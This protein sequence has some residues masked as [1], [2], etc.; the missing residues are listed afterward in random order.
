MNNCTERVD[1]AGRKVRT[2][3]PERFQIQWRDAS[4]DQLIPDD[5]R[6]RAVWAFVESLES[7]PSKVV[8][9]VILSTR[10]F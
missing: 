10:K 8:S 3:R 9:A 2:Q 5:H 1:A 6:V 4:L 7:E